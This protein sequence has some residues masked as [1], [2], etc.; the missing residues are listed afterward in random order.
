[1]QELHKIISEEGIRALWKGLGPAMARASALTTS[2][3]LTYDESKR[4][5]F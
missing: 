5:K 4:V 3:L 1:M 2:Q